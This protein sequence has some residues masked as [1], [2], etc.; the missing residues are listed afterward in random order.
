MSSIDYGTFTAEE[1]MQQFDWLCKCGHRADDHITNDFGRSPC[2]NDG[3]RNHECYT[4]SDEPI[5]VLELLNLHFGTDLSIS[6]LEY[7]GTDV[8]QR[9]SRNWIQCSTG[10][11]GKCLAI[12]NTR[13]KS[14]H[15]YEDPME[16]ANY[17]VL[18]EN[19]E[20]HPALIDA[21]FSD[22]SSVGLQWHSP[23]PADLIDTL[24]ALEAYPSLDDERYSKI[25]SEWIDEGWKEY[26]LLDTKME[27]ASQLDIDYD[28]IPERI[29]E[30]LRELVRY[31]E[32]HPPY[33]ESGGG[34][35]FHNKTV[36]REHMEELRAMVEA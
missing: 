11:Y 21:G 32:N 2:V 22:V 29:D 24:Q 12:N 36:I 16:Y 28:D 17:E 18:H 23:A 25:E 9:I 13:Q 1:F 34:A 14:L 27:L 26:G 7:E 33:Y 5:T 31:S 20:N 15:G 19:W 3:F 4:L 30:H 8:L 35:I 6:Q 10:P